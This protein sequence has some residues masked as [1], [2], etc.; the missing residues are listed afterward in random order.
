M[1]TYPASAP[2]IYLTGLQHIGYQHLGKMGNDKNSPDK[3]F[4]N[5]EYARERWHTTLESM[6]NQGRSVETTWKDYQKVE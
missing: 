5:T 1:K 2:W 4:W 6:A 3:N